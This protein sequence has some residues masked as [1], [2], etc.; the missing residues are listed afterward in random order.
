MCTSRICSWIKSHLCEWPWLEFQGMSGR[1]GERRHSSLCIECYP[2]MYK[3]PFS[4]YLHVLLYFS[5]M[6]FL[7]CMCILF[8]LFSVY[9]LYKYLYENSSKYMV[10]SKIGV[11]HFKLAILFTISYT[12]LQT[13][14][15]KMCVDH[16]ISGLDTVITYHNTPCSI[17]SDTWGSSAVTLIRCCWSSLEMARWQ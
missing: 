4:Y 6:P 13:F 10:S 2:H 3:C 16:T 17:A 12:F 8:E 9:K 14:I 1:R 7:Y 11:H 15:H 5:F